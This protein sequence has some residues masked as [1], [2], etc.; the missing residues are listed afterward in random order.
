MY[1]F[2]D[3]DLQASLMNL[4]IVTGN[5]ETVGIGGY[6]NCGGH[7]ALSLTYG[8]G[9]DQVLEMEVVTPGGDILTINECQNQD[10]FWAMRGVRAFP[11]GSLV[12]HC[13]VSI[14]DLIQ[15]GGS[16]FGIITSVNVKAFSAAPFAV[17]TILVGTNSTSDAYWSTVAYIL[18]R[19]PSLSSQGV[20]GFPFILP[21]YT[22]PELNITT[23]VSAFAGNFFMPLLSATNTSKPLAAAAADVSNNATAPYPGQFQSLVIPRHILIS[24]LGSKT[25]MDLLMAGSMGW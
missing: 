20:A 10:L 5:S 23:P 18:S 24:I 25:I 3:M 19:Y 9:A 14:A 12:K 17:V 22:N 13:R 16:T 21:D 15:G 8:M 2:G 4:T 7:G 6:L 1:R 11:P